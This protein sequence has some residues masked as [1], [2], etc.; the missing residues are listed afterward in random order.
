MPLTRMKAEKSR[1]M[2]VSPTPKADLIWSL[3]PRTMYWSIPSTNRVNPTTHMGQLLMTTR[4]AGLPPACAVLTT[5]PPPMSRAGASRPGPSLHNSI[6][7]LKS[8]CAPVRVKKLSFLGEWLL[9]QQ[10][11]PP[12][13]ELL[14]SAQ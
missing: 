2:A 3:L 8:W 6:R 12:G 7:L 11:N 5:G 13:G 1:P 14:E 10:H 4:P 9:P